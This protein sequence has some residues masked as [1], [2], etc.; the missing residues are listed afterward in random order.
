MVLIE[1]RDDE[2]TPKIKTTRRAH[3]L[4][5]PALKTESPLPPPGKSHISEIAVEREVKLLH[6]LTDHGDVG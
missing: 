2:G 1:V 6:K 4:L 3:F 5:A